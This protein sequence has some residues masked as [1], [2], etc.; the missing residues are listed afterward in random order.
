[1]ADTKARYWVAV[2]YPENMIDDWQEEIAEKLQK[3]FAYCIHD[4]CVDSEGKHRKDHVHI[5][6]VY[7]AP[8]TYKN[9][10]SVFKELEK[11]GCVALNKCER[12]IGVRYMYNYLIHD[13]E[14]SRKKKKHPYSPSERIE[15]NGFDIGS[16]EQI[17][18]H[19]KASIKKTIRSAISEQ[20]IFNFYDL[21]EYVATQMSDEAYDVFTSNQGYFANLVRGYYNKIKLYA[22]G[23][24]AFLQRAVEEAIRL[25]EME[26][27][28]IP[29][30]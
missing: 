25:E 4:K 6:L 7:G 30:D 3:P 18:L 12:V 15:G 19:D 22:S 9:A 8:T 13:T 20:H 28:E 23:E 10:M 5:M 26:Q 11:P 14:E 17:S 2:M 1:M 24:N 27:N 16:Y 21:D 29:E